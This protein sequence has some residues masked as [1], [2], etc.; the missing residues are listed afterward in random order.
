[1]HQGKVV[2]IDDFKEGTEVRASY[3]VDNKENVAREVEILKPIMT[4]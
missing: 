3:T 4:R 2:D 1:M